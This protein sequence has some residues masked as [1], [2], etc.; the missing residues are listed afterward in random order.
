MTKTPTKP[1][2]VFDD[3]QLAFSFRQHYAEVRK[4]L[5][6]VPQKDPTPIT[7]VKYVPSVGIKCVPLK[8][9]LPPRPPRS[10]K[11]L[12]IQRLWSIEQLAVLKDL[13]HHGEPLNVIAPRVNHSI[14]ACRTV[15]RVMGLQ[16]YLKVKKYA[17]PG[18]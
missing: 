16:R 8:P 9:P 5:R 3:G 12:V 1:P 14:N 4:R 2:Y 6:G 10:K 15:V 13:Y 7:P 18:P 17:K 11:D